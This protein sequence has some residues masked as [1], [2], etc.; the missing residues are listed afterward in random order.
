MPSNKTPNI[1]I[2]EDKLNDDYSKLEAVLNTVIDGIITIDSR[3]VIQSFNR[4][5]EHIFGYTALEVIG[6]NVKKLMPE[7]YHSEHDSYLKNHHETGD[8][9]IIGIGREVKAQRKNGDV[10]FHR[11][12]CQRNG[13]FGGEN[14]C[15]YH[16]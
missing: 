9:K 14:V 7:P 16:S 12:R 3:G 8:K 5:A 10:F 6:C 1:S 2:D 11:T 13:Y 15:G 4:S